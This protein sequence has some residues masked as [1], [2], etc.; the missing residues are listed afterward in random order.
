MFLISVHLCFN[1]KNKMTHKLK[2]RIMLSKMAYQKNISAKKNQL[3][4]TRGLSKFLRNFSDKGDHRQTN[5]LLTKKKYVSDCNKLRNI[6][7]KEENQIKAS[8]KN[9]EYLNQIISYYNCSTSEFLCKSTGKEDYLVSKSYSE[10]LCKAFYDNYNMKIKK[11]DEH[12]FKNVASKIVDG[13][14]TSIKKFVVI[15]GNQPNKI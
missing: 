2:H 11:G 5:L 4:E 10:S 13:E 12:A 9:F 8:A 15:T 6:I 1:D 14:C 7:E 3:A